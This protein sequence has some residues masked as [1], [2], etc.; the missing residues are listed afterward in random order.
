MWEASPPSAVVA[1]RHYYCC[2]RGPPLSQQVLL[3]K[4]SC[5]MQPKPTLLCACPYSC[6][7]PCVL[8]SVVVMLCLAFALQRPAY[9]RVTP[10]ENLAPLGFWTVVLSACDE[11][12]RLPHIDRIVYL[13]RA[14][15]FY[16]PDTQYSNVPSHQETSCPVHNKH[17]K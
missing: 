8:V 15:P 9:H 16:F 4:Y 6:P 10:Y 14:P 1:T 13:H 7:E 12:R 11:R 3:Y 5:T 17:N 2:G